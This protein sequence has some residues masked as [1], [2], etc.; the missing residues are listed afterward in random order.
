MR[1]IGTVLVVPALLLLGACGDDGPAPLV[2]DGSPRSPDD[3][4]LVTEVALDAITLDGERTYGV[5]DELRSFS[6]VDLSTV[7]LL[8]SDGQYV[9]LGLDGDTVV[10]LG[11]VA[12]PVGL[13]PPVV[14]LTDAVA[15]VGGEGDERVVTFEGGTVLRLAEGTEVPEAGTAVR[16]EIDARAGVVRALEAVGGPERSP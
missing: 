16:A 14:Y 9:Q 1:T 4:G 13:D 7:P 12:R 5:S 10:W 8:F 6:A 11:A 15:S 2:L 3:E